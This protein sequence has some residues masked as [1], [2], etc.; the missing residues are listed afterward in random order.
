[1]PYHWMAKLEYGR[2]LAL[3]GD[4]EAALDRAEEAFW[5]R[6]ALIRQIQSDASYRALGR[7]FE[8]FRAALRKTVT[9]ETDAIARVETRIREFAQQLDPSETDTLAVEELTVA[10]TEQRTV[11]QLVHASRLSLKFSL[12][13]LQQCAKRLLADSVSFAFGGNKG[14][15]P[16]VKE[17]LQEEIGTVELEGASL[18]KQLGIVKQKVKQFGEETTAIVRGSVWGGL[19]LLAIAAA[20]A[21]FTDLIGIAVIMF[22]IISFGVW[23]VWH[24]IQSLEADK[25]ESLT[26]VEFV[27][28]KLARGNARSAELNSALRDFEATQSKL[29]DNTMSFCDLVDQFEI[30]GLKRVPLSPVVPMDRKGTHELVRFDPVK[31]SANEMEFDRE[32]LPTQLRFLLES[33]APKSR[34]WPARRLKSG[35]IET[36]SRSA[37]YFH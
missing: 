34:F 29:R 22:V 10:H 7:D 31:A 24:K 28:R 32:L 15:T 14:L 25:A 17:R 11:L 5:L 21:V 18:T 30:I 9:Q 23:L 27:D 36:F 19:V 20:M 12:Q 6:P 1:M 16:S 33:S 8:Q 2:Q 3:A 26:S 4:I 35:G 13:M 37:A